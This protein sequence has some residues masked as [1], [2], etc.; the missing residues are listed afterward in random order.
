MPIELIQGEDG[1]RQL[2]DEAFRASYMQL[3]DTC[4]WSTAFQ[5]VDFLQTWYNAYRFEYQPVILCRFDGARLSGALPL[6]QSANGELIV[7]G[8]YQAEYQCWLADESSEFLPEAASLLRRTFPGRNL[9]FRYLPANLP[10]DK[11]REQPL[12]RGYCNMATVPRPL[13][14]TASSADALRGRLKTKLN[15]LRRLG[16]LRFE[17]VTD[18]EK[19]DAIFNDIILQHNLRQGVAKGLH[20][21]FLAD[22]YKRPFHAALFAHPHLMHVTILTLDKE[23]IASHIGFLSR[24]QLHLGTLT[25]TVFQRHARYSPGVLHLLLLAQQLAKEDIPLLDLTPYGE[26]KEKMATHSD[27]ACLLVL[28]S[29]RAR[30]VYASARNAGIRVTKRALARIGVTPAILRARISSTRES[31]RLLSQRLRNGS[32]RKILLGAPIAR[33]AGRSMPS[34]A[35]NKVADLL[36]YEGRDRQQFLATAVVRMEA[37]AR[38]YSWIKHDSLT[39]CM[40]VSRENQ[41]DSVCGHKISLPQRAALI[42]DLYSRSADGDELGAHVAQVCT[43]LADDR[44]A[45]HVYILAPDDPALLNKLYELGFDARYSPGGSIEKHVSGQI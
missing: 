7:A 44:L 29:S 37:H 28:Y 24:A 2:A 23:L 21:G 11:I 20:G 15:G 26:F 1:Y 12:L 35:R 27:N 31:A 32:R 25:T 45:E 34:A 10:A 19:F 41:E 6:A 33:V 13:L 3:Y 38:L 14:Q 18:E 43:S 42:S 40:W 17:R 39:C 4:R 9:L 5:H 8:G 30:L 16:D 36:L 22:P